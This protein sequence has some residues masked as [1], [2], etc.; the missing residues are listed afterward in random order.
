MSR[1]LALAALLGL[2]ALA[3][4][5]AP[6]Q[7]LHADLITPGVWDVRGA[8]D[9]MYAWAH[10]PTSGSVS[11]TWAMTLAGNQPLPGS[12]KVSFA[13]DAASL[14]PDK[15]KLNG[16]Y[17]DWTATR[18]TLTLPDNE[19]GGNRSAE[20]HAGDAIV[21][22]TLAI[23]DHRGKVSGPGSK[24]VVHYDGRFEDD[25]T[26]FDSGDFPTTLGSGQTVP[27]FDNGLMGL[28]IGETARLHIPP[29]LAYGYDNPADGN[30]G[31]FNGRTLLFIVT[32]TSLT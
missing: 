6:V 11:L 13:P 12:W 9:Y 23:H 2:A 1:A 21:P 4:C 16:K 14:S 31:K 8:P 18:I 17:P 20:L 22:V 26:R 19:P 24:V 32:V 7:T 25:G 3:G 5:A 15:T 10:N 27:G 29:A 28:A 30:Y